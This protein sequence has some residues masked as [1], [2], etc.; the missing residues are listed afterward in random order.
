MAEP[1]SNWIAAAELGLISSSFSTIVSQLFAARLGR[2]A[3]VDWMTVAAIPMRDAAL[4]AEPSWSAILAGI[5]FHQWADFSWAVIFF[6]LLGRWTA[7][8]SPLRIF[9]LAIPW[10]VFTSA[11]EWLVL[12]PLLPFQQPLFTLQQPYWTGLLVHMASAG[13]YPIFAWLRW[14]H[15]RAPSTKAVRAARAWGAG[16]LAIICILAMLALSSQ[17]GW[18][19]PWMGK[20]PE[21]DQ[22]Y[23]RH[24][25][26]HHA[27]GIELARLGEQRSQDPHLRALAS[28]MV[29]SQV[30]EI[31]IFGAWWQS[32]F[33]LPM[34]E[35]TAQERAGMP[36]YLTTDQMK[37]A[38]SASSDQF[39]RTFIELMTIHHAGAVKMADKQWRR[40][41]DP[42]LRI[43]AHAIRHG[44]QG[45]IALM[46]RIE[47]AAAVLTATQNML[48]DN[49]N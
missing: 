38:R 46:N 13:M 6:G 19:W 10:A 16:S 34:P 17:F 21:A 44:Q 33:S 42:R 48:A 37:E 22:T 24:M 32:W 2:D 15:G 36:G 1:K 31:R 9:L 3:F 20:D 29:A 23:M 39:D 35:C 25:T 8:L 5:A 43:M 27:Q 4:S 47:G 12:V 40:R 11:S 30:G 41:G 26:T 7:E 28:L 49:V 18:E 45:E 14:P